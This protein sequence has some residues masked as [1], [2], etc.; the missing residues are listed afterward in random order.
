MTSDEFLARYEK[1][2]HHL[3]DSYI[4]DYGEEYR[5]KIEHVINNVK[6]CFFSS[7][8]TIKYYLSL[9]ISKDFQQA[10]IAFLKEIGVDTTSC[11]TYKYE[12]K[13]SDKNLETFLKKLFPYGIGMCINNYH[14][15]NKLGIFSFLDE[16]NIKL[17]K[18]RAKIVESME[19][20]Y[21]KEIHTCLKYIAEV[22]K[23]HCDRVNEKYKN[24][25]DKLHS[26]QQE[27]KKITRKYTNLLVYKAAN[28]LNLK[29]YDALISYSKDID[30]ILDEDIIEIFAPDVT[31]DLIDNTLPLGEREE[32]YNKRL[33]YLEL[34]GISEHLN[35]DILLN[36]DWTKIETLRNII[37]SRETISQYLN[38]KSDIFN[39]YQKELAYHRIQ[40]NFKLTD[41]NMYDVVEFI[42]NDIACCGFL[43]IVDSNNQ[44]I[45][46]II[47]FNLDMPPYDVN[48]DHELR[49]AIET[50]IIPVD[51][52]K[53]IKKVGL[54]LGYYNNSDCIKA[55]YDN[56]AEIMT[57]LLSKTAVKK[58]MDKGL[59]IIKMPPNDFYEDEISAYDNMIPYLKTVYDSNPEGIKKALISSNINDIFEVID[60]ND[61]EVLDNILASDNIIDMDD[62]EKLQ[63]IDRNVFQKKR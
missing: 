11:Y 38:L 12:L 62:L 2:K 10:T 28:I 25:Y 14:Y 53:H 51:D 21:N 48:L 47:I 29:E 17:N 33:K 56:V 61:L 13:T 9:D 18:E 57:Q 39:L 32:I 22:A 5:Q 15:I 58:R 27:K 43:P 41:Y 23:K 63:Q 35:Q 59:C 19:E 42:L 34:I 60:K 26:K 45:E 30:T 8:D 16:D 20:K 37:P 49:H 4:E 1:N 46:N 40:N 50:N 6:F 44:L 36:N 52:S 7:F 31:E 54:S 24:T 3:I 55:E